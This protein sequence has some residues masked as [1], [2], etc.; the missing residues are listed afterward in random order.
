[1]TLTPELADVLVCPFRVVDRFKD[2]NVEEVSDLFTTAQLVSKAV[3]EKFGCTSCT[4]AIQDGKEAGQTIPHV[5][6]HVIPRKV[7]DFLNNDE[8][9]AKLQHHDSEAFEFAERTPRSF[10][11]METE[12]ACLRDFIGSKTESKSDGDK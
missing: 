11:E 6:V 1:L 4:I 10:D 12:A 9:Y 8:V 5:H 2:L 7:G 3:E